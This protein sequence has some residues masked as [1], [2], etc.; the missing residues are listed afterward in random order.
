MTREE[1]EVATEGLTTKAAKIRTLDKLGA[2]RTEI[3][4]FLGIRYQHV[5]NVLVS[6][7]P[8]LNG[9]PSSNPHLSSG[10]PLTIEE[11]KAGLSAHFGVP[12]SAIEITIRG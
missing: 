2:S 1:M 10:T 5:R 6:V 11:A 12:T 9:S 3:A 4:T 8:S 7:S